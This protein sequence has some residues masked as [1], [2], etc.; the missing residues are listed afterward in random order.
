MLG[1]PQRA[2]RTSM[3]VFRVDCSQGPQKGMGIRLEK[4][5]GALLGRFANDWQTLPSHVVHSGMKEKMCL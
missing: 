1:T 2:A 3:G 5:V 4:T